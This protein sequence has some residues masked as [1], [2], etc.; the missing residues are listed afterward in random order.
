MKIAVLCGG[1][2]LERNV[3]F[4]TGTGAAQALRQ[5]GHRVALV[6]TFLGVKQ[7]PE[8]V[9]E[10]FTTEDKDGRLR[11]SEQEPTFAELRAL[12][13]GKAL[14]GPGVLEVCEHADIAFLALHGGTGENGDGF[15]DFEDFFG[16]LFGFVA[17]ED[18]GNDF[19]FW[20]FFG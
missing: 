3:S 9:D 13:P 4:S 20:D 12:R 1:Y 6:D 5:R 17:E 10:L 15:D 11:V 19:S 18:Q 16:D 14:I 2:S 7:L 8:N